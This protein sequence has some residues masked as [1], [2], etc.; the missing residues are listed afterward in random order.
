VIA[1]P[2]GQENFFTGLKPEVGDGYADFVMQEGFSY[3]LR[4][5][6]DS[7]TASDLS[8]PPCQKK[9]GTAYAGG[10]ILVFQQP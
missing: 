6:T 10:I 8:I 2:G 3:T 9:D 4:L 7:E 5:A 1:W